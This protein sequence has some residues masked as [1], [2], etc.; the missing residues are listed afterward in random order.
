SVYDI[1]DL[2]NLKSTTTISSLFNTTDTAIDAFY[3]DDSNKYYTKGNDIFIT[4]HNGNAV[5]TGIKVTNLFENNFNL[6]TTPQ[7]PSKIDAVAFVNGISIFALNDDDKAVYYNGS[8]WGETPYSSLPYDEVDAMAGINDY[9][10]VFTTDC[11]LPLDVSM[12]LLLGLGEPFENNIIM[13]GYDYKTQVDEFLKFKPKLFR[14]WQSL[15]LTYDKNELN[16]NDYFED[17]YLKY[18]DYISSLLHQTVTKLKQNNV[19]VVG[20]ASDFPTPMTGSINFNEVPHRDI[21]NDDTTDTK[22]EQ[23]LEN[24]EFAWKELSKSFLDI[25]Y[26]ETGNE[27][28]HPNFLHPETGSEFL[29]EE[30]IKI[31]VDLMEAS[32]KGINEGNPN[33]YVFMPAIQP[34]LGSITYIE[35]FIKDLYIEMDLRRTNPTDQDSEYY[36]KYFDGITWHPYLPCDSNLEN[37]W[38]SMNQGIYQEIINNDDRT[39]LKILFSEFGYSDYNDVSKYDETS[40]CME[41]SI[42][43]ANENFDWLW[44]I[45]YFR[46]VS[47]GPTNF[48]GAKG[49]GFGITKYNKTSS[50][51][52]C[53]KPSAYKMYELINNGTP[54]NGNEINCENTV[55]NSL[56]GSNF[57]K[58]DKIANKIVS[59]GLVYNINEVVKEKKY[60]SDYYLDSDTFA[61]RF[62]NG[63]KQIGY[64]FVQDLD[65][66]QR[67][68]H[69][70]TYYKFLKD[71]NFNQDDIIS[72]D[73]LIK[74]DEQVAYQEKIDKINYDKL[75]NEVNLNETFL[76]FPN[77]PDEKHFYSLI[78]NFW[79]NLPSEIK[80]FDNVNLG[81]QGSEYFLSITPNFFSPSF[82]DT[83]QFSLLKSDC[84]M[85]HTIVHEWAHNVDIELLLPKNKNKVDPRF[86]LFGDPYYVTDISLDYY[87]ISWNSDTEMKNGAFFSSYSMIDPLDTADYPY[88]TEDFAETF[89]M[90]VTQGKIFRYIASKNIILQEKYDFFKNN[91]FNGIEYDTGNSN[92]MNYIPKNSDWT[93]EPY[94]YFNGIVDYSDDDFNYKCEFIKQLI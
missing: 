21:D 90:Y 5:P 56:L 43:L 36:E 94:K 45:T 67:P 57:L 32:K 92:F 54:Y 77:L 44:G 74:L 25:N 60:Y 3:A 64:T 58:S 63:L 76:L 68:L 35:N 11:N 61:Y 89:S 82:G 9:L 7:P 93:N 79:S 49:E 15:T 50:N 23:F 4:D 86:D 55:I 53:W 51:I 37:D 69:L 29:D 8:Y 78:Y 16:Q 80:K 30:R 62:L 48:E 52:I 65:N 14:Q 81:G 40:K 10:F 59:N 31:I 19:E 26:W 12:N 17:L 70:N 41:D 39:N 88:P 22:Y 34:H 33:A 2:S 73:I 66:N 75:K 85:I 24:Y 18:G 84:E 83:L 47:P 20:C 27:F 91:V 6:D 1:D 28:N 42:N 87:S 13:E 72:K 71:N 38:L 46:F